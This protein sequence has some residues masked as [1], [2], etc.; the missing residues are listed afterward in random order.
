MHGQQP[1]RA[2]KDERGCGSILEWQHD[3]DDNKEFL[4]LHQERIWTCLR[5]RIY[6]FTPNGDVKSLA[7]RLHTD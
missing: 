3:M 7:S 6:C 1:E 2:G 4:S 5:S